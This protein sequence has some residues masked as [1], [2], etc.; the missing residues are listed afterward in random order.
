[1]L[2]VYARLA[3]TMLTTVYLAIEE[4]PIPSEGQDTSD[5]SSI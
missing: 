3:A 5:S 2:Y 4:E 1:M